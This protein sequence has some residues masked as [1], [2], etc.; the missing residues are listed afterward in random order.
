[1]SKK[2]ST[3]RAKKDIDALIN[4]H[5]ESV[6]KA[7]AKYYRSVPENKRGMITVDDLISAGNL[8]L[9]IAAN[10]YEPSTDNK[11]ITYAFKWIDNAIKDELYQYLGAETFFL[12]D[13]ED[14]LS[15]AMNAN[16][17]ETG[18]EEKEPTDQMVEELIK[19]L[20]ES[21]MSDLEVDV[22]CALQGIGREK[23]KN[24]RKIARELNTTEM[25]VRRLAQ[26]AEKK[27]KNLTS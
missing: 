16:A 5:I 3:E 15:D 9:V 23:V 22:Y 1:M 7:A 12:G 24:H 13:D 2:P 25:Q 6:K 10:N 26:S 18:E 27:V 20:F 19:K 4:D 21:G 8:A 17:T 14:K 11:F